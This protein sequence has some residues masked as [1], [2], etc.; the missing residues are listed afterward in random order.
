LAATTPRSC[1]TTPI[2]DVAK[3]DLLGRV[4]NNG[5]DL[6]RDQ[7][8]LLPEKLHDEFVDAL[9][10]RAKRVRVG[11]GTD[12]SS[13]LGPIQTGPSSTASRVWS[14]MRSRTGASGAV[15]TLDRDGLLRADRS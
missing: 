7:A 14:T 9:A 1:S 13:Q 3:G 11:P 8:D 5:Q 15:E 12:A 6:R 4:L 2:R 10:E